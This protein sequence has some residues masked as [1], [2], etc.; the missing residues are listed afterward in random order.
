M[1]NNAISLYLIFNNDDYNFKNNT[2]A[3]FCKNDVPL[4]INNFEYEKIIKLAIGNLDFDNEYAFFNN[5][6]LFRFWILG[7]IKKFNT[8]PNADE[9]EM[10]NKIVDHLNY[11]IEK[12]KCPVCAI[13]NSSYDNILNSNSFE[14]NMSIFINKNYQTGMLIYMSIILDVI[15][16]NNFLNE[17]MKDVSSNTTDQSDDDFQS[18]NSEISENDDNDDV[19]LNESAVLKMEHYKLLI[20]CINKLE[21]INEESAHFFG[22]FKL[23]KTAFGNYELNNEADID[24]LKNNINIFNNNGAILDIFVASFY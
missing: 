17:I 21:Q 14:E 20:R 9:D 15:L 22:L 11:G 3:I 10:F 7:Y 18:S 19:L 2:P 12:F 4:N 24:E 16:E 13:L 1:N 8:N 23:L 5:Q 6:K